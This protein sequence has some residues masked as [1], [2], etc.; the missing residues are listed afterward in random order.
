MHYFTVKIDVAAY[1]TLGELPPADRSL[2]L[3]AHQAR[4]TAYAP[5][6]GYPVGA[7][8]LLGN[9][10]II[11]GS[12][13]ENAA[14]PS[15]LCAERVA[16]FYAHA[17]YPDQPI[18]AIAITAG[19]EDNP[20]NE[21][22]PPCGSCRQVMVELESVQKQPMRLIMGGMHGKVYMIRRAE[23]MLPFTFKADN[24]EK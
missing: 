10:E 21:P 1:P 11:T 13:Q 18:L 15:G 23:D 12:N 4:Q 14:Y 24:L 3:A 16:L 6:S 17:R 20:D 9:G 2:L 5:Y 7:A 8:V 22:V 19:D